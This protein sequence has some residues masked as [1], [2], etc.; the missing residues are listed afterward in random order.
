MMCQCVWL[1]CDFAVTS[2]ASPITAA[3]GGKGESSAHRWLPWECVCV[4]VV[5][6]VSHSWPHLPLGL[7][8]LR[9]TETK[10]F[11]VLLP[12]QILH[13]DFQMHQTA[14]FCFIPAQSCWSSPSA[15]CVKFLSS[16]M[17]QLC[18]IGLCLADK[19]PLSSHGGITVQSSAG[20]SLTLGW[21]WWFTPQMSDCTVTLNRKYALI[22][23]QGAAY[24]DIIR[25]AAL[26][27]R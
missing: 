11:C 3:A 12:A 19:Q 5:P 9:P 18:P 25:L 17:P 20:S 14:G 1:F 23:F 6:Q 4:C 16:L 26:K 7:S 21:K 24:Q 27:M 8:E 2:Y 10:A 13:S 22:H 15:L